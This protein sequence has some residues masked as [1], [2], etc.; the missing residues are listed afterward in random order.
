MSIVA[1]TLSGSIGAGDL[2][3]QVA[4]ATGATNRNVIQIDTE[5]L[6][7]TSD[8]SGLSVPV[9]RGQQGSAAQSHNAGAVV[10]MGLAS[11]FP[12]APP[13]TAV[14]QPVA[15]SW[16]VASY[17]GAGAIAIPETKQNV[18]VKLSAGSGLAMTLA[19]PSYAQEGQEMVIQAET[20]QAFTVTQTTPGFNGASTSGDVATFGGAIGDTFHIKAVGG[21]WNV[22]STR[23]VTIA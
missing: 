17:A 15:P 4:S 20:A 21:Q 12:A 3:L 11:D 13:G 5:F 23:N 6:T 19:A 10:L 2:T 8:A 16:T 14:P 18:Y 22:L 7:Q 1:T 9:R